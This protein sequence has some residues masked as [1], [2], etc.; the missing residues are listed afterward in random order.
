M[1]MEIENET[2]GVDEQEDYDLFC[3]CNGDLVVAVAVVERVNEVYVG[4]VLGSGSEKLSA[5]GN[6]A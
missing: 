5:K 6:G 3:L 1:K 2:N 4:K